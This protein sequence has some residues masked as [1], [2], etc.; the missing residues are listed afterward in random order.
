MF[1]PVPG[2]N[3]VELASR[4]RSFAAS[5]PSLVL[6][7]AL[8]SCPRARYDLCISY[9]R[10]IGCSKLLLGHGQVEPSGNDAAAVVP[11]R[12]LGAGLGRRR[13]GVW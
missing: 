10:N 12:W 9:H 2:D 13:Q 5:S 8:V 1:W 11:H 6:A 4:G 7:S 3:P